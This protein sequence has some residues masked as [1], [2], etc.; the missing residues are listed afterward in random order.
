LV[1]DPATPAALKQRGDL[2]L[3]LVRS[4]PIAPA[5]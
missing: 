3:G 1:T 4:G 2:Y 5:K